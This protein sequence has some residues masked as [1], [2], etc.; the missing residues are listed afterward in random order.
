MVGILFAFLCGVFI[1]FSQLA[2]RKSYKK[3]QPSVAFFFDA[4]FGFLI[5]V[6][7]ALFMGISFKVNWT[8][9]IFYA[10]ISAILS[11]AIVFYALSHGKLAVTATV[12]AT[13]P[14]YTVL[15]QD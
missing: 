5:W 14:V 4:I 13:Y 2:L 7:L 6:P 3:L 8:E 12:L 15:F 9:A 11:E 1:A 10:A